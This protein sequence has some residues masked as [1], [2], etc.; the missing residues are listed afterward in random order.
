MI[1]LKPINYQSVSIP[2]FRPC[3]H[4]PKSFCGFQVDLGKQFIHKLAEIMKTKN[5]FNYEAIYEKFVLLK[6]NNVE[7]VVKTLCVMSF[8]CAILVWTQFWQHNNLL[9]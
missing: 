9:F 7:Q 5:Q 1:S 6:D 3:Q 8:I 4:L 2:T